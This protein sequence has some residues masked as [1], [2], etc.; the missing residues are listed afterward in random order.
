MSCDKN[1]DL[2]MIFNH[3]I[4]KYWPDHP[5]IIYS[6]ETKVNP[7]YRTICKNLNVNHWTERVKKTVEEIDDDQ[8]LLMCDDVFIKEPVTWV[9][10]VIPEGVASVNLQVANDQSWEDLGNNL[11]CLDDKAK[12]KTSV[13]C[14]LWDKKKMLNVF[15]CFLD[16]WTFERANM[17]KGY[18]YCRLKEPVLKWDGEVCGKIFGVFRSKWVRRTAEFLSNEGLNIDFDKRGYYD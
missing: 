15:D 14:S 5:E 16:P 13:M 1:Q 18:K 12:Y 6:T 3:C 8:I 7:Y 2:W 9:D 11:I 4:K 17:D 10:I